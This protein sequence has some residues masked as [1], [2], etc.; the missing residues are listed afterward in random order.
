LRAPASKI[1]NFL[2]QF[3]FA[4]NPV[5]QT[6][7]LPSFCCR[8][9]H[10]A[11]KRPIS[12]W[13]IPFALSI[14]LVGVGLWIRLGILETPVF[15]QVVQNNKIVKAPILEVIK[16]QPK[17]IILSACLRMAEQAPFYIFTAFVFAYAVGTLHMS[18]NFVLTAGLAGACLSFVTIPLSG[19]IS[20][21]IGRKKLYLIG[22]AVTQTPLRWTDAREALEWPIRRGPGYSVVCPLWAN[23]G[24]MDRSKTSSLFNQLVRAPDYELAPSLTMLTSPWCFCSGPARCL[25][26]P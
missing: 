9:V 8:G 17:E 1:G 4:I 18:R 21:R 20:D 15:Q 2:D 25:L 22:A 3:I 7:H 24:L 23:S 16:L 11:D 10:I 19:H 6:I 12:A 13:R 26:I 5:T 14:I